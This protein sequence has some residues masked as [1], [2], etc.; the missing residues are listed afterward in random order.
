MDSLDA[1]I[2]DLYYDTISYDSIQYNEDWSDYL[3][4]YDYA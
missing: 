2:A 3:N 1:K 4:T